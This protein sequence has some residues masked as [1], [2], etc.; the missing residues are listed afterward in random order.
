MQPFDF[1]FTLFAFLLG[2]GLAEVLAGL[3]RAIRADPPVRLGWPTPLLA[4]LVMIDLTTFWAGAWEVRQARGDVGPDYLA[5]MY[6]LAV[7]GLYYLAASLVF[8]HDLARRPDF[9]AHYALHG[10]QVLAGIAVCNALGYGAVAAAT[11]EAWP[12]LRIAIVAAFFVLLA[13]GMWL[14]K[15]QPSVAVLVALL[16]LYPLS[17]FTGA[18]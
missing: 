10:W 2:L 9:D 14:R 1:A 13:V 12:P 15:P 18:Q 8:P 5:L 16:A 11:G 4:L 6:G 7:S 3:G 17:G